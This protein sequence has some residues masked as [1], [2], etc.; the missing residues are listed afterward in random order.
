MGES[1][2]A[3]YRPNQPRVFLIHPP[4]RIGEGP[5]LGRLGVIFEPPSSLHRLYTWGRRGKVGG[6]PA[7][8]RGA[9]T[10]ADGPAARKR[11][12]FDG[13]REAQRRVGRSGPHVRDRSSQRPVAVQD[14]CLD[15][16]KTVGGS[17]AWLGDSVPRT[18]RL[19]TAL[20]WLMP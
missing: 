20:W 12:L 9:G 6:R 13:D 7:V 4:S 19:P 3:P 18:R 17:N 16:I 8:G 1:A 2:R 14:G 15:S 5:R 10:T 11:L